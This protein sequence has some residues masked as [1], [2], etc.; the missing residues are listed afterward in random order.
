MMPCQG[1]RIITSDGL[2]FYVS[3]DDVNV[4]RCDEIFGPVHVRDMPPMGVVGLGSVATVMQY[5]RQR[6]VFQD[7]YKKLYEYIG[8]LDH[9]ITCYFKAG[10]D[11]SVWELNQLGID[12]ACYAILSMCIE[13]EG[14]LTGVVL[15]VEGYC[16]ANEM[17]TMRQKFI[18]YANHVSPH[19][20]I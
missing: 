8:Y 11:S 7:L 1:Y 18:Q 10:V 6:S 14:R 15:T 5:A 12:F 17:E 4:P 13:L 9:C 2:Y 3:A 19:L 16:V 20:L